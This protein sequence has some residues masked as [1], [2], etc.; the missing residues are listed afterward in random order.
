MSNLQ[1]FIKELNLNG[2]N[3]EIRKGL[4]KKIRDIHPDNNRGEFKNDEEKLLFYNLNEAVE[5]IDDLSKNQ[6]STIK[7]SDI[8]TLVS[9]LSTTNQKV[10]MSDNLDK[11]IEKFHSDYKSSH[12]V[13]KF[14][15]T[16]VTSVLGIVWVFP[17]QMS[18][19]PILGNLINHNSV[20]FTGIWLYSILLTVG[21][22]IIINRKEQKQKA[23]L[24]EINTESYQNDL[25]SEYISVISH[26]HI[27]KGSFI[28]KH[29]FTHFLTKDRFYYSRSRLLS[30]FG[31]S[32]EI[33]SD[34]AQSIADI[35]FERAEE[36][37]LINK[38]DT[39]S[40]V[41]Q[42]EIDPDFLTT[43]NPELAT[44]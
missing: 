38:T 14:S 8:V 17:S 9:R 16:G 10:S 40:L 29:Q 43:F 7:T 35:I 30:F 25:F 42:Y 15:L 31:T 24:S 21:F 22:W 26:H 32:H 41:D 33:D 18:E 27:E 2:D 36:K 44:Q 34:I 5:E 37:G 12:N 4:M 1:Y 11:K 28:S 23:F 19:H 6:L 39:K 3:S 20:T 13:P